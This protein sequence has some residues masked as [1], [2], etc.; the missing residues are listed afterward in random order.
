MKAEEVLGEIIDGY[1]EFELNGS[2]FYF[3]HPSV[4]NRLGLESVK[5]SLVK[6][7]KEIGLLTE[8]EMLQNAINSGKW[9]KD[10][11][12]EIDSLE[13]VIDSK[14]NQVKTMQDPSLKGELERSAK[15]DEEELFALINE[16]TSL[17]GL[18]LERYVSSKLPYLL[19]SQEVFK[20]AFFN[21]KIDESLVKNATTIYADKCGEL[22]DK[23]TLIDAAFNHKFFDL[24]FIYENMD[25]IF[26]K[27]IYD[28]TVFQRDL[29]GYGKVLYSK[30]TQIAD[31]PPAVKKNPHKL[32]VYEKDNK[33][34]NAKEYNIRETVK[35]KGGIDAMRPEDKL[36]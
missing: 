11:D 22:S 28:L 13:W 3:K 15:R 21:Q 31:I 35:Q 10:K 20:D 24:F 4:S 2:S 26:G 33:N 6:R 36:T 30:L 34:A 23:K 5:R 25:N 7:A 17:C 27:S 9:S 19:C 29:L 14:R 1:S 12:D 16:K 32:Y 8:E 18:T